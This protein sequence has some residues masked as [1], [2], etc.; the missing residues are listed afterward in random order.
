M[1][2]LC[3][4][5]VHAK[6]YV[7]S[8]CYGCPRYRLCLIS[9]LRLSTLKTMSYLCVTAVHATDYVLSLGYGCPRY[10]LCLIS[11]LRLSTL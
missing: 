9:V 5:A 10:R 1:S 6:D 11:V 7:L 3:V 4:T 2:Y 8:L